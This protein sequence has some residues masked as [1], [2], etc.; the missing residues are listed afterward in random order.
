MVATVVGTVLVTL[1]ACVIAAG[2]VFVYPWRQP[3]PEPVIERPTN[4]PESGYL[5]VL[6]TRLA[7][8]EVQMKGLPSLW[9]EERERARKHADR[10]AA[11]YR[12]AEEV[13]T[14]IQGGDDVE[15]EDADL[16]ADDGDAGGIMSPLFADVGGAQAR[17][18]AE[19]EV[20]QKAA[21]HLAAMG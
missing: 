12:G 15:E 8:L 10:A 5:E 2:V 3:T 4:D 6:G 18:D 13:L 20:R 14:A 1:A 11:A 21:R 16:L 9:E 17:A 7:E 19:R